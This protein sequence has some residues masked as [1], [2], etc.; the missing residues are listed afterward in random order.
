MSEHSGKD[1]KGNILISKPN[2]TASVWEYFG[3]KPNEDGEPGNKDEPVCKICFDVV[4]TKRANTTNLHAHLRHHHPLQYSLLGKQTAPQQAEPLSLRQSTITEGFARCLKY[5]R[6]SAKWRSLTDSVVRYI[7]KEMRPFNT[8]DKAA[9][10][11]MLRT[12]DPQ[13]EVPGKSYISQTAIP[14]LY[15]KVKDDILNEI[16]NIS[17]YSAT[18]D[19]WSS[20]NMTPFISLTIHY[21]TDEW[22]LH[23]KCLETKYTS[24]SHTANTLEENLKAA[25]AD[26]GLDESKLACI[27]TDNGANI[28]AAIRNLGW[29]WL[30]CFG[31][32]L[33]LAVSHALDSEKERTA[34]AIGLCRSLVNIFHLSWNKR[35][36]LRKAQN[37]ANLPQHSLVLDVATR[38]GT[39]QKMVERVLE[40]LPAIRHVLVED[41]KHGHLNPTWQDISVLES[42]NAA[43]KPVADF[44]DVLSGEKY[45]TVSSVRPV[46]ELMTADLLSPGPDDNSL[47][48]NIKQNMCRVLMSKYSSSPI[49]LLLRKATILDPRYRASMEA[50]ETLEDIKNQLVQEILDLK[51]PEKS[52][53]GTSSE[54]A[55]GNA[56]V[57]PPPTKKKKLSDLLQNRKA[58]L[59]CQA[60]VPKS[61]QVEAELSM[62]L[63]EQTLDSSSHPLT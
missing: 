42:I 43:M 16:K 3:F 61:V 47:T 4:S 6:D 28:V 14:A 8:V 58:Q 25:F 26:W 52:G 23:S 36:A 24:E 20:S 44:T 40:Q 41:R 32:N 53:E 54:D 18:T 30:N 57:S 12:F 62:Y 21:I 34:R 46:L 29:P 11:D 60:N 13:Y 51:D 27:T 59:K 48:A 1:E 50:D 49:Q 56:V 45:V 10:R 9:F 33:H 55:R 39:K 5:K 63:Q 19:M 31:H 2:A 22:T 17:F 35:R 37:D 7:A 38:W 15:N